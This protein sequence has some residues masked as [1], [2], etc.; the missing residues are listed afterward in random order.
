MKVGATVM[1]RRFRILEFLVITVVVVGIHRPRVLATSR[2]Y[3]FTSSSCV[4]D[5]IH[6]I[7][8]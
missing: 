3:V 1:P 2:T 7:V 8:H 5:I 4:C 6:F